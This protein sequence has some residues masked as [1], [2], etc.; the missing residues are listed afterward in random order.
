[1]K[2]QPND[3]SFHLR[4]TFLTSSTPSSKRVE[5][6]LCGRERTAT[7]ILFQKLTTAVGLGVSNM[8]DYDQA[9]KPLGVG[10]CSPLA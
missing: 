5:I 4:L 3:P 1:M 10:N 8:Y 7:E 2:N 9:S 6:L